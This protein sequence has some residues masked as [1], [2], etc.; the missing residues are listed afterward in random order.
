MFGKI[1]GTLTTSLLTERVVIE[2]G[3]HI[4]TWL[5]ERTSNKLD[6]KILNEVKKALDKAE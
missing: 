1:I 4:L 2:V 5:F 3:L 6:D